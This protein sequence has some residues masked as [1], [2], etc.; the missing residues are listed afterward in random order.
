T[1]PH[2]FLFDKNM[3]LVYKGAIDDN[4]K[5]AGE[6]KN[7]WLKDAVSSLSNGSSVKVSETRPLGCSIKRKSD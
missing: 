7:A 1:T 3:E 4:Y 5:S 6:V 2:A